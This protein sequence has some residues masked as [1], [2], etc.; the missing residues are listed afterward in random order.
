MINVIPF[1]TLGRMD[2]D[3]L[4][5]RFH[6][7]FADYHDPARVH[8][9]PLRVWND[10]TIR[11]QGGFP[12]HPHRDMEIITYVRTGA[13]T[14]AD[15]LGNEGRTEAGDVQV[16]SAGTGIIHSEFNLEDMDT[17]LFQIWVF[18]R[19]KSLEP[20][21]DQRRF[22][23]ESGTGGLVPLASGRKK[24]LDAGAILIHQDATLFGAALTKGQEVTHQVEPG[25]SV[26]LV[27]S[28][29]SL[30][31]N[32]VTLNNRD[33]ATINDAPELRITAIEDAEIVAL[34]LP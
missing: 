34:D 1:E 9:G 3:W 7:S 6:F 31:I 29:G 27:A 8:F 22:P 12:M 4:S 14:H 30:N 23:R 5:A 26:Y 17:T 19:E 2:I 18:P 11:P 15:S 10:D 24:D 25:R 13:I 32:G 21:W 16:M 33:G 20:R 28:R